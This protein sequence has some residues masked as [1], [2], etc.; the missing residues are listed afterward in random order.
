MQNILAADEDDCSKYD[1][2]HEEYRNVGTLGEQLRVISRL[3]WVSFAHDVDNESLLH[4]LKVLWKTLR[5]QRR[6]ET[7][8]IFIG[9]V[10][11]I[12]GLQNI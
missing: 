5:S 7:E 2:L 6:R 1:G 12:V 10:S 9:A 3:K 8:N 11:N 4:A